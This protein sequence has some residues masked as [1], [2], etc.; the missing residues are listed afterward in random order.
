MGLELKISSLKD[1]NFEGQFKNYDG[2]MENFTLY[3]SDDDYGD[4]GLFTGKGQD[5]FGG[6]GV[7]GRRGV[8]QFTFVK[9]YGDLDNILLYKATEIELVPSSRDGTRVMTLRGNYEWIE[10][11]GG[12]TGSWEMQEIPKSESPE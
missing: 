2:R 9:M 8:K 12:G 7:V 6:F 4:Y 3:I 11:P 10:G 5:R 1:T